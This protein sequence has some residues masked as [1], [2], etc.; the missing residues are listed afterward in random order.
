MDLLTI[1]LIAIG[2]SMDA[3]AVS[4]ANGLAIKRLHVTHALRLA[5]FFGG[6][7][8]GMPILGY[9]AGT[10][11]REHIVAIDHWIAFILLS[12]IGG[13][14]IHEAFSMDEE[15]GEERAPS[16]ETLYN[17]LVLS[18]ATSIDAL[19]VGI[20]LSFLNVDIVTPAVIIGIITFLFSFAGVYL[21][22]R[23]GHLFERKIEI[24]GGLILIGIGVKILVEHL[25]FQ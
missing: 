4:I 16:G 20:S 13:K 6:F 2:L 11:V 15:N 14:M 8:A 22:N 18:I 3:F 19:A 17:L 23:V 5:V 24:L 1:V 21:G 10:S 7:Q 9:L 12:I 25:F